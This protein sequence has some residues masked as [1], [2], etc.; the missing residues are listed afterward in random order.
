MATT[1]VRAGGP[2]PPRE[3]FG[4][5]SKL[6]GRWVG[7]G[8]NLIARPA[9]QNI[10][11][12]PVFFLQL[13]ATMETL[14]FR[15]IGGDVPNRGFS[16]PTASLHD[17]HYLQNVTDL[18]KNTAIHFEPGLWLHVPATAEGGETY[19]REATIPHGD[20]L[21]AQ[22]IFFTT[23]NGGPILDPVNSFP[24]PSTDPIPNLNADPANPLGAPYTDPYTNPV[25][26]PNGNAFPA[27]FLPPGLNPAATIKNPVGLL[28]AAIEPQ[29][30]VSTDVIQISTTP[31]GGIVN[32][33]FVVQNANAVR[34]D[35][36][37]WIEEVRTD[38]KINQDIANQDTSFFQLQYVQRVIL[39]FD[40]VHW[41]HVSV[42]TLIK[43]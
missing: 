38:P 34:M 20:S 11:T 16:E 39:D 5:L 26:G 23:V 27:Q 17:I 42:A 32:I 4:L 9:K 7:K 2:T 29:T 13:N 1:I 8:F 37:F 6:P 21:L 14:E 33:P 40:N 35:A 10:A 41:P 3:D 36:I 43:Q 31:I 12:N 22:S 19:V 30:F 28:S 15:P 24:F 25:E 18:V